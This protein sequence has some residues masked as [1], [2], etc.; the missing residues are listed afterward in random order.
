MIIAR[1][2]KAVRNQDWFA[3]L[4]EFIIVVAGVAIGFKIT[5]LAEQAQNRSSLIIALEQ[6]ET[7]VDT[8]IRLS[9]ETVE[10][11]D[12]LFPQ[13]DT[14]LR[15]VDAC[16]PPEDGYAG[17]EATILSL[18]ADFT[19][20]LETERVQRLVDHPGF[21]PHISEDG[22]ANILAYRGALTE[23]RDQA[24][25]NFELMWG[26]HIMLHPGL[27]FRAPDGFESFNLDLE[28]G[29]ATLCA[30]PSFQTRLLSTIAFISAYR[31]RYDAFS[32]EA[33]ETRAAIQAE[34]EALR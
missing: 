33:E 16:T 17:L 19:V 31:L 6:M 32:D 7:E 12:D 30:D 15:A 11:I 5:D 18:G 4:L 8:N 22:Q 14:L 3:A 1:L 13:I 29:F 26:N 27:G 21:S 10:R 20:G 25:T 28:S 34:L 23:H 2:R 24:A 9:G